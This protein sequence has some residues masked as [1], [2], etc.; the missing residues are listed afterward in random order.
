M[1]W[2]AFEGINIVYEMLIIHYYFKC[3]LEIK[4]SDIFILAA[5]TVAGGVLFCVRNATADLAVIIGSIFVLVLIL[6]N[7]VYKTKFH[8]S[9]FLSFLFIV[10]MFVSEILLFSIFSV[11][12]LGMPVETLTEGPQRFVGMIGTKMLSFWLVFSTCGLIKKKN[13]ALPA[14]HWLL[15][16]LTPLLSVFILAGN[17]LLLLLSDTDEVVILLVISVAGL[18]YINWSVFDF[19]ESYGLKMRMNLLEQVI[20]HEENN[21]KMLHSSYANL[22]RQKHDI[23]NQISVMRELLARNDKA[24]AQKQ[25]EVFET[26]LKINSSMH[27]SG[28]SYIDSILNIKSQLAKE[29]DIDFNVR[30]VV[31]ELRLDAIELMRIIG[32]ALDNAIEECSEIENATKYITVGLFQIN[33]QISVS[34]RNSSRPVDTANIVTRK[35]NKLA[36]GIGLK[37]IQAS[38]EKL[39]GSMEYQYAEGEFSLNLVLYNGVVS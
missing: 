15:I 16:I 7:I 22:K 18:L 27:Y 36:H 28:N 26:E 30:Y 20:E 39:K 11:T 29:C 13:M 2:N 9:L 23:E 32:N 10:L 31:G 12:D 14:K 33:S 37:S 6:S 1:I 34:I 17:A 19:I 4:R 24:L 35:G 8:Q 3:L 38:V 5:Y 25:L 21:Y